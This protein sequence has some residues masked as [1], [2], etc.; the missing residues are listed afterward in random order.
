MVVYNLERLFYSIL[1]GVGCYLIYE[2]DVVQKYLRRRTNFAI[3]EEDISELPT[4]VTYI[5]PYSDT[6]QLGRDFNI[7][8]KAGLLAVPLEGLN[9]TMGKNKIRSLRT[10]FFQYTYNMLTIFRK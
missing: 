3:H 1:L 8:F 4:I 2:G 7:Q 10:T 5:Y 9:L 6:F